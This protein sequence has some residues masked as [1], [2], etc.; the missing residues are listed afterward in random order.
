MTI[1]E[2]ESVFSRYGMIAEDL[3]TGDKRIKL[4]TDDDGVT[5][6]G[7]A[8]IVYFKSE[9]VSLAVDMLDETEFRLT[10]DGNGQKIRVQPVSVQAFADRFL[11]LLSTNFD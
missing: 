8:L 11:E 9:S 1:S 2:L 10:K 5:L 3:S 4:Y 6:K 7:D